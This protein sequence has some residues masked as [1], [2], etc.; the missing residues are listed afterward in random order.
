MSPSQTILFTITTESINEM[1]QL[2]PGQNL[3]PLSIGS[4]LD[5]FPKI[6]T[7]KL[8]EMFQTFIR[9]ERHIP[10][11]PPPYVT[12]IFSPLGQDIVAM[13]SSVLGYTTSEYIDE[14]ILAFMSIYTPGQPLVVIYDYAKFIADRMH[15]QF[16]R[17]RN[18]RVL[19]CSSVLYHIFLY[20]QSDKFPFTLQKLDTKG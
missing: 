13:I 15:D 2:Q 16:L 10:K 12:A 3:T 4:L 17:M 18:E 14:I 5:Q 9:E 8:V 19:K 6:T 1:L 7:A 11:D 20:Y